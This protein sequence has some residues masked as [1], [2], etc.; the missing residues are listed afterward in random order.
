LLA[1]LEARLPPLPP[2]PPIAGPK[3]NIPVTVVGRKPVPKEAVEYKGHHYLLISGQ[4]AWN[5]AK[6][7]CERL[8][9]HLVIITDAKEDEFFQ[10]LTDKKNVWIGLS[11][12]KKSGEFHWVDGTLPRY[13][14][15][16]P[17]DPNGPTDAVNVVRTVLLPPCGWGDCANDAT[18]SVVGYVCEWDY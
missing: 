11:D 16:Q 8:G 2:P 14:R 5:Q 3:T 9:G 17:G 4:I 7:E 18:G 1:E 15:W 13:T 6:Q 12:E 10:K